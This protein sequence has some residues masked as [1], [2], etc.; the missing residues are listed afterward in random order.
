M[1]DLP[2]RAEVKRVLFSVDWNGPWERL[3]GFFYGSRRDGTSRWGELSDQNVMSRLGDWANHKDIA[4][5][6]RHMAR[7]TKPWWIWRRR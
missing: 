2:T 7:R 4:W 3:E 1:S 6:N 5:R